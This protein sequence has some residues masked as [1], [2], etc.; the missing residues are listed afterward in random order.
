MS[1]NAF[2]L[3]GLACGIGGKTSG[4]IPRE[5]HHMTPYISQDNGRY[6]DTASYSLIPVKETNDWKP[7]PLYTPHTIPA[8]RDLGF[9]YHPTLDL[10]LSYI[11]AKKG[12]QNKEQ[13]TSWQLERE[14]LEQRLAQEKVMIHGS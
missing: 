1:C 14:E 12:K 3:Y 13:D 10:V 9:S 6:E 4:Y 8:A 11:A 5:I 2:D 7:V